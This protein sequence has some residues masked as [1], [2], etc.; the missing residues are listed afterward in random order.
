M[1]QRQLTRRPAILTSRLWQLCRSAHS[2]GDG[3]RFTTSLPG[4]RDLNAWQV[5]R[6]SKRPRNDLNVGGVGRSHSGKVIW[7]LPTTLRSLQAENG[8]VKTCRPFSSQRVAALLRIASCPALSGQKKH[9]SQKLGHIW[10]RV[11][12]AKRTVRPRESLHPG[13]HPK[14][15]SVNYR[16]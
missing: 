11:E 5:L 12:T 7:L 6:S 14:V 16:H 2:K 10:L 1:L 9:D 8:V 3:P 4:N 13:N 15:S